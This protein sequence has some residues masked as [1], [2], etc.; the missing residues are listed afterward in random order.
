ML[1][2]T[3]VNVERYSRKAVSFF[4]L[5]WGCND[6]ISIDTMKNADLSRGYLAMNLIDLIDKIEMDCYSDRFKDAASEV[7]TFIDLVSEQ[8]NDNSIIPILKVM[9][10]AM[11]NGDNILI[12]DC[13]E[14]GIKPWLMKQNVLDGIF[15]SSLYMLPEIGEDI[16]YYS[17]FSEEPVLCVKNQEGVVVRLNSLF[18]PNNEVNWWISGLDLNKNTSGVCLFGLGTGLFAEKVLDTISDNSFL[19][20]Y[21]ADRTIMQ[22]CLD[23]GDRPQADEAEKQISNRI[24]K[25][26]AD[27]R[28][29]ILFEKE[30]NAAFRY[31]LENNLDYIAMAGLTVAKHNNYDRLYPKSCLKFFQEINNYRAK[32]LTNKNTIAFFKERHPENLFK[33][34]WFYKNVNVCTD[35]GEI[36]PKDVPVVIVSAGPSL[37]KNVD[38]LNEIKGRFLIFAVDSAVPYLLRKDIIP[39]IAITIDA[40][41]YT[42]CFS[43]E[44]AKEIPCIFDVTANNEILS[45]HK[46]RVLL[47]NNSDFYATRLLEHIGIELPPMFNGGSVAT[48]AFTVAYYWRQKTIILIGQDLAFLNG[49]T[50]AGGVNDGA[51]NETVKVEG[52][53]GEEIT[54]RSDWLGYLKWF[55]N[56]IEAI[57]EQD[58]YRVIDATEGGAKIHGS[59]QMTLREV[60]D[61]YKDANG[62]L[63]GYDF[64]EHI[65][66]LVFSID[67]QKYRELMNNLKSSVEKLKEIKINA[68]EAIRIC[69]NLLTRIENDS[70]T[71][72]FVDNEKKKITKI[73]DKCSSFTF[74]PLLI[75]YLITDV[76]DEISR[77]RY[78]EGDIKT[79]EMNG[80]RLMLISFESMV[81]AA[82]SLYDK[83]RGIFS[84]ME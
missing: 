31:K 38:L 59:E 58:Y 6:M 26:C 77:L 48:A 84:D 51:Q 75:N 55:E 25:I 73:T 45:K 29:T 67:E 70:A 71:A 60:I 69:K 53:Y 79:V 61:N 43:D 57:K 18:S 36:L 8:Y 80:I 7:E 3:I 37:D 47:F 16:Y 34:F 2:L 66:K 41:K 35:V 11:E 64:G 19:I 68:D 49:S 22:Y 20:I 42:S 13:L 46:G 9:L 15:D 62:K 78:S 14:Y 83:A 54:T 5:F 74:F 1:K 21:E 81:L 27:K 52:Y 72:T 24:K 23:C 33:N 39:D 65:K 12:G 50:H 76:V 32:V 4:L 30:D 17:S 10:S 56:S 28:V 44:R 40:I 82:D 63:S